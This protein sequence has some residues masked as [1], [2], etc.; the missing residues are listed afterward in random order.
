MHT[1]DRRETTHAFK[2]YTDR[3]T[4]IA[5][6]MKDRDEKVYRRL[7]AS[8]LPLIRKMQK[9]H[10]QCSYHSLVH[11]YCSPTTDNTCKDG[12]EM[13]LESSKDTSK[14]LTQK[15]VSMIT[16]GTSTGG[17]QEA[18]QDENIIRHH[19]PHHKVRSLVS[20][21]KER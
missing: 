10:Q 9:F 5:G 6:A 1:T 13:S 12:G 3:E 14:V 19:T 4:E 17:S 2:D 15:E 21:L 8:V 20:W 11:Y 16:S 7:G 18:S